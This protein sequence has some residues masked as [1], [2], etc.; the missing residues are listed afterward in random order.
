MRA[1]ATP[2]FCGPARLS[3]PGND[4]R[5][6]FTLTPL[7]SVSRLA[8]DH[9][10]T[11][12][13]EPPRRGGGGDDLESAGERAEHERGGLSRLRGQGKPLVQTGLFFGLGQVPGTWVWGYGLLATLGYIFI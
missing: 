4:H 3:P 1:S 2:S 13:L 11:S 6:L 7:S 8:G 9:E 10:R 12:C 5:P